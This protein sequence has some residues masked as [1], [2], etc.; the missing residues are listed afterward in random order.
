MQR[1]RVLAYGLRYFD[2]HAVFIRLI[3][4]GVGEG[5]IEYGPVPSCTEICFK[6]R[7]GN[8]YSQ[9]LARVIL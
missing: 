7:L 1:M 8:D 9:E 3:D 4:E 6:H 2:L 5:E